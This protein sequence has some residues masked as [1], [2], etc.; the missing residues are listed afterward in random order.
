M[1]RNFRCNRVSISNRF[2]DM[3]AASTCSRTNER[4]NQPT[5]TTYRNTSRWIRGFLLTLVPATG[6]GYPPSA[7]L[8]ENRQLNYWLRQLVFVTDPFGFL[9]PSVSLYLLPVSR[10]RSASNVHET[11]FPTIQQW[12]LV[13]QRYK[14]IDVMSLECQRWKMVRRLC[15]NINNHIWTFSR[16]WTKP[17]VVIG[18]HQ[19]RI[20]IS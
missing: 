10:G 18:L 20:I 14:F 15:W 13:K 19:E 6:G 5:N 16:W 11:G 12:T 7:V 2:Q 4:T 1:F 17:E 3:R 8:A 9:A